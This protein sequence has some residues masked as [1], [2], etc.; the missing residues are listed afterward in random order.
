MNKK[1]KANKKERAPLKWINYEMYFAIASVHFHNFVC[2]TWNSFSH[3]AEN[4]RESK[5][6]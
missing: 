2:Y 3:S 5:F 1:K 6:T 4:I